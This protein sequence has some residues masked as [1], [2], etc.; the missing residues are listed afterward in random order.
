MS[1]FN[2][3]YSM[4]SRRP[5]RFGC[6]FSARRQDLPLVRRRHPAVIAS[7]EYELY[8]YTKAGLSVGRT[9]RNSRSGT[10]RK[11]PIGKACDLARS[12]V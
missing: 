2:E 10:P 1:I 4:S 9:E 7:Q 11:F 3:L 8:Y 12:H 6:L 5:G